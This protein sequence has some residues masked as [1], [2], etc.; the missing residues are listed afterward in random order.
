MPRD[1]HLD[2]HV[3]DVPDDADTDPGDGAQDAARTSDAPAPG[4]PDAGGAPTPGGALLDD[5]PAPGDALVPD[6]EPDEPAEPATRRAVVQAA[7]V[8]VAALGMFAM[9]ALPTGFVV[10]MPGPTFDTL[11]ESGGTP[12]IG[13]SGASTYEP[14]GELR[15]TTVSALGGPRSSVPVARLVQ[16]WFAGDEGIYPTEALFPK[17]VTVE[18]TNDLN[19]ADMVTS[20]ERATVAALRQLGHQ[21]TSTMTVDTVDPQMGAHGVVEPGDV[22]VSLDG[23]PLVDYDQLAGLVQEVPAGATIR[24]GVQR[25]GETL[26]LDVVTTAAHG[27]TLL[28]VALAIDFDLPFDV[29]LHL[30]DVGGPSAGMMFALG[31]MDLLTPQDEAGGQVIAGT[32][33]MDDLAG[34]VGPIGG[35]RYK[36]DGA[37]RDGATWFLA[38]AENCG[39]VVGNVPDGLRVVKVSTL[40]GAYDAVVAIGSGAGGDLPTCDAHES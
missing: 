13:I 25:G 35:I 9:L 8:L 26:E 29:T 2:D 30:E 5:V 21:V 1:H 24:L 4:V 12:V 15:L 3:P 31:I 23:T 20:Q 33:T 39:E 28:G 19:Q 32:G 38:P 14:S 6:D 16:A 17:G 18:Q 7:A 37:R 36:L 27:R 11:A 10:R 40:T 34:T 22:L